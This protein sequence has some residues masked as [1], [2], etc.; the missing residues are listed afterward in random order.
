MF[1]SYF[2]VVD[3]QQSIDYCG[4][5]LQLHEVLILLPVLRHDDLI[6]DILIHFR[7]VDHEIGTLIHDILEM[8]CDIGFVFFDFFFFIEESLGSK[9]LLNLVMSLYTSF[10]DEPLK[11]SWL[12]IGF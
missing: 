6:D 8:I 1:C 7:V 4:I 3:L 2:K 10:A 5:L 9:C 11:V 12:N